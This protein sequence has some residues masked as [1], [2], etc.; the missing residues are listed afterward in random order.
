MYPRGVT[1]TFSDMEKPQMLQVSWHGLSKGLQTWRD[2]SLNLPGHRHTSYDLDQSSSSQERLKLNG[3]LHLLILNSKFTEHFFSMLTNWHAGGATPLL[4]GLPSFH[5][6]RFSWCKTNKSV[7]LKNK[8]KYRY[9][10]VKLIKQQQTI[11]YTHD[12]SDKVSLY[13]S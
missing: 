13:S 10:S 9:V 1:D 4:K 12:H 3:K 8:M 2:D 11:T 6:L 7:T 5:W